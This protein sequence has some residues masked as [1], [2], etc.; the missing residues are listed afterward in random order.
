MKVRIKEVY[1]NARHF[2]WEAGQFNEEMKRHVFNDCLW[3]IM[4]EQDFMWVLIGPDGIQ[5]GP[6]NDEWLEQNL[7]YKKSMRGTHVW[8]DKWQAGEFVP[9]SPLPEL[10]AKL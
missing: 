5:Y 8:A 2:H 9:F 7:E 3:F 10:V 4:W 1:A 6:D